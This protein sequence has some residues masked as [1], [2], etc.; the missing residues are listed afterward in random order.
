M[1]SPVTPNPIEI[2]G[3]V[4]IGLGLIEVIKLLVSKWSTNG[5]GGYVGKLDIITKESVKQTMILDQLLKKFDD[6]RC[7]LNTRTRKE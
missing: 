6:F 5:S 2:G 7:P 3:T 4:V 1:T